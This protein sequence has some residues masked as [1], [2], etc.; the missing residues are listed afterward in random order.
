MNASQI[1]P[2]VMIRNEE[3]WIK[4]ILSP[5]VE[6]FPGVVVAD[7]GSTDSTVEQARKV[8]GVRL[9]EYGPLQPNQIGVLRGDLQAV[10][11]AEFGAIYCL[12]DDGDELYPRDYL[13]FM[14]ANL[15]PDD[16][17]GGFTYGVECTE[18]DNGELWTL[19]LKGETVGVSRHALFS[20]DSKWSGVYPFESPDTFVAGHPKNYYWKS[21]N[22]RHHFWHLHQ[23][24]RS[25]KDADVHLRV[26]KRYQFSMRECPEIQ[27]L[28]FWLKS[29]EDYCDE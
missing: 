12:L 25:S 20:V 28:D 21:E 4:R 2:I 23:C 1:I 9:L 13:R 16:T 3:Y 6:F 7:T 11:K 24:R 14:V 19:G 5:L 18:L 29:R 8:P 26:Q 15:P 10:A 22:P 27:P 17:M